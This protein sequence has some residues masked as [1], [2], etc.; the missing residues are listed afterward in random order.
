M[1]RDSRTGFWSTPKMV[2]KIGRFPRS[3]R[4]FNANNDNSLTFYPNQGTI[5]FSSEKEFSKAY[6]SRTRPSRGM[7]STFIES[8][9]QPLCTEVELNLLEK[10]WF[11]PLN[12]PYRRSISQFKLKFRRLP[13][14]AL[15]RALSKGDFC[16][17]SGEKSITT[18]QLHFSR[19]WTICQGGDITGKF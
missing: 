12:T 14:S 9:R 19:G 7:I 1:S 11:F 8:G 10:S 13:D 17:W 18:Y 16:E 5:V 15:F 3:Q 4:V 2:A 6:I